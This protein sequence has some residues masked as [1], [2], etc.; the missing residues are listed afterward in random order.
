M[1]YIE[2]IKNKFLKEDANKIRELKLTILQ[3][4]VDDFL[5]ELHSMEKCQIKTH[6]AI[7]KLSE[8]IELSLDIERIYL[9][10]SNLS[11]LLKY[12]ENYKEKIR[13]FNS[14]NDGILLYQT[15]FIVKVN[16]INHLS[17][18]EYEQLKDG[19]IWKKFLILT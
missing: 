4:K 17:E 7:R 19:D 18:N 11:N 6:I 3:T 14:E 2:K 5:D 8:T 1:K 15:D 13:I 10:L 9:L 16:S 12:N